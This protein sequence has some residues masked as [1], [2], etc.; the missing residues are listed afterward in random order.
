M[1]RFAHLRALVP[2]ALALLAAACATSGSQARAT[3][4]ASRVPSNC[5]RP[6]AVVTNMAS[7]F[8]YLVEARR[9][10]VRRTHSEMIGRADPGVTRIDVSLPPGTTVYL[11]P[12]APSA[13]EQSA[14]TR[15]RRG[16]VSLR[17]ECERRAS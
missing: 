3:G 17:W 7:G 14:R 6:V 11:Q 1:M 4:S 16:A 15:R 12:G 8:Y 2:A 9:T 13:A 10:Y 5:E